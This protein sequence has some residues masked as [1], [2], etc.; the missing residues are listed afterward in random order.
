[1]FLAAF[2]LHVYM[3][4]NKINVVIKKTSMQQSDWQLTFKKQC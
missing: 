1:M 4:Y 3:C 2:I